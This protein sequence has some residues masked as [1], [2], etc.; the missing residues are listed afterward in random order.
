MYAD[1]KQVKDNRVPVYLSD[2][3]HEKLLK[4]VEM[5][6]GQKSAVARIALEE[7]IDRLLH[8]L[9]SACTPSRMPELSK[10]HVYA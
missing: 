10:G 9:E 1:P 3:A 2:Y 8:E 6:G 4:L 5:Q 7:G